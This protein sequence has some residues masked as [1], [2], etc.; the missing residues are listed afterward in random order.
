MMLSREQFDQI[1]ARYRMDLSACEAAMDFACELMQAEAKAISI[2]EPS[3]VASI[4][5]LQRGSLEARSLAGDISAEA[6]DEV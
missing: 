5:R 2:A 3:A 6:F 1:R 4:N